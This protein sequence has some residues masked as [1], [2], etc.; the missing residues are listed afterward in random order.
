MRKCLTQIL[1]K[2]RILERLNR[3]MKNKNNKDKENTQN[4][5]KKKQEQE[6]NRNKY[7]NFK[8]IFKKNK[9]TFQN[10]KFKIMILYPG[11]LLS[12]LILLEEINKLTKNKENIVE[13]WLIFWNKS[14][15]ILINLLIYSLHKA[16]KWWY[17]TLLY[18]VTVM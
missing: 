11:N 8:I 17:H 2:L 9:K 16:F 12:V 4:W 3:P 18:I 13:R 10:L 6:Q 5:W 1:S 15:N 7:K 14:I